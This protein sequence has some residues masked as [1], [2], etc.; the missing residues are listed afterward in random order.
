MSA[1]PTS[2]TSPCTYLSAHSGSRTQTENDVRCISAGRRGPA[3][4]PAS[5]RS[6]RICKWWRVTGTAVP[7]HLMR[8]RP[9]CGG[10]GKMGNGRFRCVVACGHPCA[11]RR[12][13]HTPSDHSVRCRQALIASG[14]GV[15][16]PR[17]FCRGARGGMLKLRARWRHWSAARAC[18]GLEKSW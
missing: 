15:V 6:R 8:D 14:C 16:D 5:P 3:N 13:M 10:A 9:P 1:S 7:H 18:S 17:G 12:H 4:R 2:C 11:F